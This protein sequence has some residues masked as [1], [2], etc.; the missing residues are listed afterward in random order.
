MKTHDPGGHGD[1]SE[2]FAYIAIDKDGKCGLCGAI[3]TALISTPLI[4]MTRKDMHK[5]ELIVREIRKST[6]KNI[7]LIRYIKAETID[8]T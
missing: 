7:E 2:I 5:Y 1:V 8:E 6:K 3:T 4:G